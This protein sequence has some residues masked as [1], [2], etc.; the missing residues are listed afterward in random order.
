MLDVQDFTD[1]SAQARNSFDGTV[2]NVDVTGLT[3]TGSEE[4]EFQGT[5]DVFTTL[6]SLRDALRGGGGA[7]D[8]EIQARVSGLLDE[9]DA[10]HEEILDGV[11]ELGFRTST[12]DLLR[13]RVENLQLSRTESL[14]L[15]QDT[16]VS[17]AIIELQHQDIIYQAA[18]QI[19]A[20]VI[21]TN[22]QRFLG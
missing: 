10:A 3:R 1:T 4:V 2:L 16:D 22:L 8:S 15:V 18:L 13:E 12:M 17:Q 5:F 19:G 11:R 20:R 21:Q 14:S 6:I 9:I 7:S